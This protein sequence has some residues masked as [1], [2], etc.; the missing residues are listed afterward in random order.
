MNLGQFFGNAGQVSVGIR[1][2]EEAERVARQNQLAIEEQNRLRA[3]Q[4]EAARRQIASR[5]AGAAPQ[6]GMMIPGQEYTAPTAGLQGVTAPTPAAPAAAPIAPTSPAF[7]REDQSYAAKEAARAAATRPQQV[8]QLDIDR[9]NMMRAPT[10]ALDVVQAPAAA[11]LNVL[12][13]LGENVVNIGGRLVNAVT[14][15]EIAPTNVRGPRFGMTP[16]YDKYVREREQALGLTPTGTPTAAPAAAPVAP[17]PAA[18]AAPT[19]PTKAAQQYDNKVTPYDN[20][21]AQSAQ[22]YGL[23]PVVFKRLIGTESSFNPNAEA[24][25]ANGLRHVGLAQ[26]SDI[27]G[28]SDADRRN[29]N[30]AIPFA[31]QLFSGYLQRAGGDYE[32]ALQQYKGASSEKGKAAMAGPIKTILSGTTTAPQAAPTAAPS[33]TAD[34]VAKAITAAAPAARGTMYGAATIDATANNPRVQEVLSQRQALVEQIAL[35]EQYGFAMKALELVPQVRA[36]D[37]GLYKAQADQG[38]YEGATTGN[39]SRAMSV[40]SALRNMPHQVLDR[41]DRTY[42]LYV[43]GKVAKT[44]MPMDSLVDFVRSATDEE[45]AKQKAELSSSQYKQRLKLEEIV[46]KATAEGAVNM[47][48]ALLNAQAEMFRA[49][50]IDKKTQVLSLQDG[51]FVINK[52][53]EVSIVDPS[54]M[55]EVKGK[56]V[57]APTRVVVK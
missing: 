15:E 25:G 51:K 57:P 12:S 35:M 38:V 26:I 56:Q 54:A 33:V 49:G 14:G 6:F 31:A 24:V 23:D 3:M 11:G 30:I 40:L 22:Q 21:I 20:L 53:G 50:I 34:N 2:A 45:Y 47:Q 44:A 5:A 36:I 16:F 37:L 46:T 19:Q 1:Q 28:L 55:E 4:D 9:L 10:A 48:V 27:H 43:G 7:A 32:Q 42:D 39:F 29:P 8:R 41:G 13:V 17:K 18:A 52:G